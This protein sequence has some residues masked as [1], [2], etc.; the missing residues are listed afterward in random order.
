[1]SSDDE[2]PEGDSQPEPRGIRWGRF[3]ALGL[4]SLFGLSVLALLLSVG[5]VAQVLSYLWPTVYYT[6]VTADVTAE[7]DVPGFDR[8][9][10]DGFAVRAA[11][12]AG[13]AEDSP[14]AL[15]LND[16]VLAAGHAPELTVEP[17]T[18]TVIATG[19][20]L[21]RGADAVVMVET[22]E[23]V[24]RPDGLFVTLTRPATPGAFV[25]AAHF[26]LGWPPA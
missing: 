7:V 14:V 24:E 16:E 8:S 25:A 20:M 13:A 1:M 5:I 10:V 19:G 15:R 18:A 11:D 3:T 12:T 2:T 23:A 17:G 21:P 9:V 22:T 4:L 26:E 6:E